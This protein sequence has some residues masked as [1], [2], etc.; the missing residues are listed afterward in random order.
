[1]KIKIHMKTLD[2]IDNSLD[3]LGLEELGLDED[4]R[5]EFKD[6]CGKWFKYGEY[7]VL[8]IDTEAKTCVVLEA[9]KRR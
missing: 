8:E 2:C 6:L 3:T 9:N 1:M 5:E 4:K 7:V